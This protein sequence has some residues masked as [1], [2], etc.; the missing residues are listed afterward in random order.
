MNTI[1]QARELSRWYGI[2]MGLNNVSFD[3]GPGLTG[4]VGPNGAGK[5]TL[6]QV[7]TGQ[8]QPSS[9]VLTVFG[10]RPWNN[11][12]L[13]QRIG[14]C[15]ER[16]S[17]AKELRPVAWLEGLGLISGLRAQEARRRAEQM[18]EKVKLAR[19]H[20]TKRM[21]QFSKGMRQRVKLAQALLHEPDLLILDEPM[22]GLDPMGRQEMA[23]ILK[24]LAAQ[25]TS[26]VISSHILAELEALCQSILILNWGRI[27]ASGEQKDIR[28]D[29]KNW[30]EQLS[31]RCS[32]PE[33]LVRH[34]F[35][36]GVLVGFD[37]ESADGLLHVRVKDPE[38]FYGQW[39]RLLHE[40]QTEVFEIRSANRSLRRIFEK[41]TT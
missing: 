13:L 41:V 38:H 19:E 23:Q 11:P 2:V 18:L 9:G 5:S 36:A 29:L 6:F 32:D 28:A 22:N 17:I 37:L 14:Y 30:S 4:V 34:L 1:I 8:L 27:L 3:I 15:P 35:E 40:S 25:G 12:Q 33:K 21:A 20:W 39:L 24:E 31:I 7:I 26:I 10:E 16:E